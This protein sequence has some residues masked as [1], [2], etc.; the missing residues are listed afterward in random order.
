MSDAEAILTPES[1]LLFFHSHDYLR[2]NQRRQEHLASLGLSIAGSS[3]LE[4]AAGVGDHTSF[5]LDRGCTVVST[6]V[7]PENLQLLRAR[8]PGLRVQLLDLD[9]PQGFTNESFDIVYCYGALYHLTRPAEALSFMSRCCRGLLL[10]ETC[11]SIGSKELVNVCEEP[12]QNPT[13]SVRGQGCR[14]TRLWI[15]NQLKMH[16]NFVYLPTT[17]PNHEEFPID[18]TIPKQPNILTRSIFI[19]SKRRL[20]NHCLAEGLLEKQMRH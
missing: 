12:K 16:F 13:Q 5:F 10:L 20:T 7:R 1:P 11:V 6:E 4:V 8:Y 2:H 9:D 18:W 14:P 19:A 17:Q 15:F 3:V